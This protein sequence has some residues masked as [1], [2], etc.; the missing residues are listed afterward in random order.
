MQADNFLGALS[1]FAPLCVSTHG[2]QRGAQD[3]PR[4]LIS[5]CIWTERFKTRA[6]EQTKYYASV[7]PEA[8]RRCHLLGNGMRNARPI[9]R[10]CVLDRSRIARACRNLSKR[11]INASG[12]LRL[13]AVADSW[14]TDNRPTEKM[15]SPK[16][17][18]Q[19]ARVIA[20]RRV[21]THF[22]PTGERTFGDKS[23]SARFRCLRRTTQSASQDQ[24]FPRFNSVSVPRTT[25]PQCS[26]RAADFE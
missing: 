10:P 3:S 25:R 23:S 17:A 7:E 9:T 22:A 15:R 24:P 12:I 1:S 21:W 14:K 13:C 26:L 20:D 19:E 6:R 11:G 18:R 4:R 16:S 2:A 8:H 5:R